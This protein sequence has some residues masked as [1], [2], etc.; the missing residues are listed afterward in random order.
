[1]VYF[2]VWL[3]IVQGFV[4]IDRAIRWKGE[5]YDYHSSRYFNFLNLTIPLFEE[6]Q[7]L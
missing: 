6:S 4:K 5:S 3:D 7:S 1:V 2:E